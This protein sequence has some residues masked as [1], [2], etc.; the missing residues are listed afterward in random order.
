MVCAIFEKGGLGPRNGAQYGAPFKEEDWED[1]GISFCLP[2]DQLIAARGP[3]QALM[4]LQEEQQDHFGRNQDEAYNNLSE[5]IV[6][7]GSPPPA[8]A[9]SE[10][11]L[12]EPSMPVLSTPTTDIN[13]ENDAVMEDAD[14]NTTARGME[15]GEFLDMITSSAA[16]NYYQVSNLTHG[17]KF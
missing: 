6:A 5:S 17:K 11:V 12:P 15:F 16:N 1:D 14:N 9:A 4:P 8:L 2:L 7:L 10:T 3:T 13:D